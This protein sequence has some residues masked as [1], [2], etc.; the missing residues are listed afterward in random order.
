MRTNFSGFPHTMGFVAFSCS[1]RNWWGNP[2]ISHMMKYTIGW[3]CYGEKSLILWG[4]YEYQFPR[5]TRYN[6]FCCIFPYYGKLMGNPM[7]FSYDEVCHRWESMGKKRPY[8]GKNISINFSDFSYTVDF[9]A[10]ACT[11]RSWWGVYPLLEHG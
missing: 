6:G 4:K 1:I 2:C 9:V 10:F 3:E 7:H 5:F 11:M 8:Y